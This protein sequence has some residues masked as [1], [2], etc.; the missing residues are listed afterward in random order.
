ML[1][2]RKQ[3]EVVMP[4]RSRGGGGG[5]EGGRGGI[6]THTVGSPAA[7]NLGASGRAVVKIPYKRQS[8]LVQLR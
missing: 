4:R 8:N 2:E 7:E 3:K 5:G 6:G 1:G